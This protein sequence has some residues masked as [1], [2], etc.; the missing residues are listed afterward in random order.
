MSL[1][2]SQTRPRFRCAASDGVVVTLG[3]TI[4]NSSLLPGEWW[5]SGSGD[6]SELLDLTE[7]LY[8][9]DRRWRDAAVAAHIEAMND[10][11]EH[12]DTVA[13]VFVGDDEDIDQAAFADLCVRCVTHPADHL[14]ELDDCT[15]EL[16]RQ[17]AE[18]VR[19]H[20]LTLHSRR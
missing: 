2:W 16:A 4:G 3:P 5:L 6:E 13:V 17:L 1:R 15:T 10:L 7:V 19:D 14:E 8:R 12:L 20:R 9:V 18:A 11:S